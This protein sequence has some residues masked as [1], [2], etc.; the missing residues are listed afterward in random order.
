MARQGQE[1]PWPHR[2]VRATRVRVG[3]CSEVRVCGRENHY[4]L[5]Q[6]IAGGRFCCRRPRDATTD[7]LDRQKYYLYTCATLC[8][9]IYIYIYGRARARAGA[10]VQEC[11][12]GASRREWLARGRS[13]AITISAGAGLLGAF[14]APNSLPVHLGR[15]SMSF[16]FGGRARSVFMRLPAAEWGSDLSG[17]QLCCC[18]LGADRNSTPFV[19]II[20]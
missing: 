2:R 18:G 5:V 7:K 20:E 10:Q 11:T 6:F 1:E 14:W 12:G 17:A 8:I 19:G 3:R 9:H 4:C 13:K 15:T 16:A